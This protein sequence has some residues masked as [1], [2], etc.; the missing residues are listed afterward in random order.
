MERLNYGIITLLLKTKEANKIQQ[1]RLICLLNV[2]Y[3]NFTENLM[4]RMEK[5]Y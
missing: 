4:L 1:Y 5:K 3:K 2:V